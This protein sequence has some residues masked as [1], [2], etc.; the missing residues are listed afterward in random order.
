[1]A[2][3][4]MVSIAIGVAQP[5]GPFAFLPSAWNC[6]SLFSARMAQLGYESKLLIDKPVMDTTSGKE[7][8]RPVTKNEVLALFNEVLLNKAPVHRFVVYFAGHG[9][10]IEL[11]QGLWLLSDSYSK[12]YA[13]AFE[14]LRGRLATAPVQQIAIIS[15]ACR[16]LPTTVRLADMTPDPVLFP[17]PEQDATPDLDKFLA[18]LDGNVTASVPGTTGAEDVCVFS[19]VLLDALS[20]DKADAF[21][22]I[23]RD[24]ITS[25]SLKQYIKTQVPEVARRYGLRLKPSVTA[26]FSELDDIYLKQGESPPPDQHFE[27]PIPPAP[28]T[29]PDLV[30]RALRPAALD[31]FAPAAGDR[32][33]ARGVVRKAAPEP[34]SPS[35]TVLA[36]RTLQ[37]HFSEF[38][39]Y[40]PSGIATEVGIVQ[41]LLAPSDV[42]VEIHR[43]SSW[44]F[45]SGEGRRLSK[46]VTAL[47]ETEQGKSTHLVLPEF[48]TNVVFDDGGAT[49]VVYGSVFE[50]DTAWFETEIIEALERGAVDSERATE[51]AIRARMEKF[52]NPI[53]GVF[54]AY[55]YDAIGD[56]GNIRRMATYFLRRNQPIPFDI[57]LLAQVYARWTSDGFVVSVPAVPARAPRTDAENE[58]GWTHEATPESQGPVAGT[59]PWLR[60]GWGFFNE[61][62]TPE[63]TLVLPGI[64]DFIPGLTSARFTTFTPEAG[65]KFARFMGLEVKWTRRVA[66]RGA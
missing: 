53:L 7:T 23:R 38:A 63:Q 29:G 12:S 4:R 14:R 54:A 5:D 27:W 35:K 60:Q 58:H 24:C 16:E 37:Q 57:A 44:R 30:E 46:P 15:D 61:L 62:S 39:G 65:E 50:R 33:G 52:T 49:G 41:R 48:V 21:S 1:M 56:I 2:A 42:T 40:V 59:W 34:P 32:R 55:L 31:E 36:L 19:G 25:Q 10:V 6:A 51:L 26:D 22:K 11:G 3:Q 8:P 66:E 45:S 17:G 20:G 47:L 28:S 64:T 9:Q 13:V 43:R 18:S